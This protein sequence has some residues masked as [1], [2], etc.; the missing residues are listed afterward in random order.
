MFISTRDRE[1]YRAADNKIKK[2]KNL[3]GEKKCPTAPLIRQME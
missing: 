2:I 3:S 1:I